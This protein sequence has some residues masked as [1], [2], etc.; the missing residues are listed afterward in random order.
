MT[1]ERPDREVGEVCVV[2]GAHRVDAKTAHGHGKRF[3]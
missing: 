3:A 2:D 1:S